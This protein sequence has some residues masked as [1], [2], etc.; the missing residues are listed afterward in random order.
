MPNSGKK[1]LG[2][3]QGNKTDRPIPGSGNPSDSFHRR[4][5]AHLS[6]PVSEWIETLGLSD[7]DAGR[8]TGLRPERLRAPDGEIV[9][10]ATRAGTSRTLLKAK[11]ESQ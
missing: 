9:E 3:Q 10:T 1:S 8:I 7:A 5:V 4:L 6:R 2:D 11:A